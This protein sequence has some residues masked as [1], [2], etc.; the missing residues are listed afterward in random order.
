MPGAY[1]RN[2][3]REEAPCYNAAFMPAAGKDFRYAIGRS[4]DHLSLEERFA[5]VNKY[6]AL[7]IYTPDA[8]PVRRIE[9]IGDS[10]AECIQQLVARGLDPA[11]F[12]FSRLLPPY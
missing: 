4:P 10:A 6:I 2:A 7:E 3:G 8:L 9:A 11:R 12:E 1:R 5:L